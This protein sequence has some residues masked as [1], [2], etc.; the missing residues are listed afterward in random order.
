MDSDKSIVMRAFNKLF[1][2]M[3]DDILSVYPDNVDMLTGKETFT[4]FKKMNPTSIVKVWF[5]GVYCKYKNQIES[6]DVDFFTDKDYSP[7]L[8]NVKNVQTVLDIINNIREPIKHMSVQNKE[9]ISKYIQDL[10]KLSTTYAVLCEN[11]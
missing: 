10:S 2:E 7:D 3:L 6:G 5:S 8:T 11:V 9:H 4:T 1:F